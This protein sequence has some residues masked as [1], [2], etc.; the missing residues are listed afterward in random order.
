MATRVDRLVVVQ[1]SLKVVDKV[2]QP[3][4]AVQIRNAATDNSQMQVGSHNDHLLS[5]VVEE[6]HTLVDD[7]EAVDS[8]NPLLKAGIG[9]GHLA[10]ND[11]VA[12]METMTIELA[13]EVRA[14]TW[15]EAD[16]RPMMA[17]TPSNELVLAIRAHLKTWVGMGTVAVTMNRQT[18]LI[19]GL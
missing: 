1:H 8:C 12:E 14:G 9:L 18:Q 16:D 11:R 4:E 6:G 17:P 19:R 7:P 5:Q 15:V 10:D 2:H 3:V 13:H